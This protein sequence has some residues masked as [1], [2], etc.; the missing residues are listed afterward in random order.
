MASGSA[1]FSLMAPGTRLRA[2][3]GPTNV[4]LR[5]HVGIQVPTEGV[6]M[7]VG[8]ETRPWRVGEPLVFDDSF[9]HEVCL[10]HT[11]FTLVTTLSQCFYLPY[12]EHNPLLPQL[13]R[14]LSQRP[15]PH[16]STSR[17]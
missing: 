7:R 9:E 2:H 10:T 14:V 15:R 17:H 6:A 4:R 12:V 5:V 11:L 1:Y 3:C 13:P 8:N 16:F